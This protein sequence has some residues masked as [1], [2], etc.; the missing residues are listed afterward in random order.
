LKSNLSSFIEDIHKKMEE[1]YSLIDKYYSSI[2]S[3]LPKKKSLSVDL[4]P[5]TAWGLSFYLDQVRLRND[6][7]R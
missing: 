4:Y 7:S 6:K 1:D 2:P 3:I 5:K